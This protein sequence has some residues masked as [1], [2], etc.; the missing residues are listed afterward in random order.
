MDKEK[1]SHILQNV[2][3]E[4]LTT[5]NNHTPETIKF[6]EDYSLA[7]NYFGDKGAYILYNCHCFSIESVW[8]DGETAYIHVVRQC[9]EADVIINSLDDDNI[10]RIV[11]LLYN[12]YLRNLKDGVYNE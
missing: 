3:H 9:F 1:L 5:Q 7:E 11:N 6:L 4:L 8:H 10:K 12:R 2:E